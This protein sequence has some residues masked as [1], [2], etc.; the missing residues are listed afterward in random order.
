MAIRSWIRRLFNRKPRNVSKAPARRRPALEGLEDRTLLSLTLNAFALPLTGYN[1]F[2]FAIA[3][4]DLNGNGLPSVVDVDS[5]NFGFGSNPNA[6]VDV[7]SD[8]PG[9]GFQNTSNPSSRFA[10]GDGSQSFVGTDVSLGDFDGRH[11]ANGKPVLDMAVAIQDQRGGLW[12]SILMNDGNGRFGTPT[13]YNT[14]G[15]DVTVGDFN[16]DGADDVLTSG[17]AGTPHLLLSNGDGTFQ[18]AKDLGGDVSGRAVVG[19]FDGRHYANGLP[20]LDVAEIGGKGIDVLMN[21]GDGTFKAPVSYGSE[22]LTQYQL[23]HNAVAVGD[24]NADGKLDLAVANAGDNNVNVLM[25]KGDGT[26]QAAVNYVVGNPI[27]IGVGDFNGD[28]K[29]DIATA[30]GGGSDS[31]VSVL[32]GTGK[33]TFLKAQNFAD[34]PAF[35]DPTIP[36]QPTIASSGGSN[37][38]ALAVGD[39]AGNGCSGVAV[40][41]GANLGT[42]THAAIYVMQGAGQSFF[43]PPAQ[44]PGA[45]GAVVA[46][47]FNGD[48]KTD[49]AF[50]NNAGD[51][52]VLALAAG[53]FNGDGTDG[54]LGIKPGVLQ[55]FFGN[56]DGAFSNPIDSFG[57]ASGDVFAFS[58]NGDGTFQNPFVLP[59][60]SLN[61]DISSAAAGDFTGNGKLDFAVFNGVY[62]GIYVQNSDGTFGILTNGA[63]SPTHTYQLTHGGGGGSIEV[64]DFN[65]DGKLDLVVGGIGVLLGNGDG[66]F[67]SPVGYG[68]EQVGD[69]DGR[70]YANGQPILDLVWT[71]GDGVNVSLGNGDGTF[72]TPVFHR[73]TLPP[74]S[75]T[76]GQ[77]VAVGDFNG[78]GNLDIAVSSVGGTVSVLLGNGDGTFQ[79]PYCDQVSDSSHIAAGDFTDDGRSGIVTFSGQILLSSPDFSLSNASVV[80]QQPAGTLVGT[81]NTPNADPNNFFTYTFVSGTGGDDN[82]DFTIDAQGNLHTAAGFDYGTKSSYSIRVRSTDIVGQISE[83][84]FTIN[85]L[86]PPATVTVTPYDLSY[87]GKA[88]T[89]AGTATGV[90]GV[91]LSADLVLAGTTHTGA[92]TYSDSWIFH[93]PTGIYQ[94]ASGAISNTIRPANAYASVAGYSIFYDGNAHTAVASALDINGNPLPASDF[95]LTATMHTNAGISTDAWSFHDPSGNYQDA[96]GTV[97][98]V[99][100]PATPTVSVSD[101]GGTYNGNAFA[102]TD[103]V[104]GVVAGVDSTPAST[105]EGVAPTLTYYQGAYTTLVALNTAIAGGLTGSSTAPGVAGSYTVVASFAGSTDYSSGQALATF[106]IGQA[107][108]TVSV[109][110]ASGLYNQN[111]F[112]ATATVAGVNGVAGPSLEGVTP[113]LKYYKGSTASGTPLAGAPTTPGTYTVKASF[114]GSADYTSA[115]ATT[116]LTIQ[117]PTTSITGPTI[118]VPGQP[119]TYN[120][121]VNGPT[122]G[123]VFTINYGDGTTLTSR[124][125]GPSITLDHVYHT[126]N[127]FTIQVTA[128]D[129]NGVVSQRATQSVKI[130]TVAM[131]TDPTDPSKTALFVGG[132]T[133]ADTITIKPADTS[134]T[135]NVKIGT[136]SFG[137]FTPT[138]H[139]VVYG[140]AGDDIIKLQ[141]A[142]ISGKTVYVTAP[143]FLFGDAGNDTIDASGSSANN[144]LEG[145]AGNDTLRGGTGRDLLIGGL[146][147]DILRGGG[148]GAD[149]LIDGT[150]DYDGNLSALNAIMAEWGRTDADYNTRVNHLSGTLS[151]G[152]SGAT[153]LTA[154]TVHDDTAIDTLYVKAGSDWF[155]AQLSGPNQD[156]V[157]YQTAT[158]TPPVG[159]VVRFF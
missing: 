80:E 97:S 15:I 130:S 121:T 24:F 117:T 14:W 49:V 33:G 5:A 29:L 126:T 18:S 120:F 62:L 39:F 90:G 154:S 84:V 155:F 27:S 140:Q 67:Q 35:N 143:A 106:S 72:Q 151:G 45:S 13:L 107:T 31:S 8:D 66:T 133:G 89:A 148:G 136:I 118:G 103:S 128:K 54:L 71:V 112:A 56:G 153:L 98:D 156:K 134:G 40:L 110:D 4:G 96:N 99:I 47:D 145:G 52:S 105:L 6:D 10:A 11:Y 135:L 115:S 152:Q 129:S 50:E 139:I 94:D 63:L 78:D 17:A 61:H 122:Q 123:I 131:E 3:A 36:G 83:G 127:T 104:A 79:G 113:T 101:A 16:G 21:N 100:S 102:A 132:T 20:I 19:D 73:L 53:N 116:N 111:P 109:S 142:V 157:K 59:E 7:F 147:A 91:D 95:V 146:G 48:G 23:D 58:G 150:T 42:G 69:F 108:P 125:G 25:G 76:W 119:L 2:P 159:I 44:M 65:G 51:P 64:G 137:N 22:V 114:A 158:G 82:A 26:F 88:H 30:N 28:G 87:D 86:P 124:A 68:G 57:A 70:H 138:D 12:V 92:G 81:F 55:V 74:D 141:S 93:D 1:L 149:I 75:S 32:E 41:S 43:Q 144:V 38:E 77:P 46:G 34:I 9:Y 37:Y 85:V 60:T